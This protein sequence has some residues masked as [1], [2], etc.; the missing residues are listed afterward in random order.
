M[1]GSLW[2]VRILQG[3]FHFLRRQC[4]FMPQILLLHNRESTR[5]KL[6]F[7]GFFV[8]VLPP[9][10]TTIQELSASTARKWALGS[11]CRKQDKG[12]YLLLRQSCIHTRGRAYTYCRP[13]PFVC[14]KQW[15]VQSFST[16]YCIQHAHYTWS[17]FTQC[18]CVWLC[19]CI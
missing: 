3:A 19:G 11:L 9:C 6:C 2:S 14:G 7:Q 5:E 8:I 10:S 13:L 15:K 16:H 1:P 4:C 12:G 18:K 17:V